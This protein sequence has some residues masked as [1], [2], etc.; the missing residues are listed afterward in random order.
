MQNKSKVSKVIIMFLLISIVVFCMVG[1][2]E[3]QKDDLKSFSLESQEDLS[4]E[5]SIENAEVDE[6]ITIS[7]TIYVYVCGAVETPGVYELKADARVY[8]AIACAGGLKEDADPD[9]INQA[10]LLSDGEQIYIPTQEEVAQG[11]ISEQI[12]KSSGDTEGKIDIN[13]ATKEE[14]MTLNGIGESR[15]ENIL[16]YR[17]E[18]GGF[19][20][21]EDLMN[22][23][24]IKEGIF[25]KIK[26]SITV[27]TGS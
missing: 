4:A 17:Q 25:Q 27:N 11:G 20:C 2:A 16:R 14:L 23:E 15:A 21:I 3:E 1:C 22:V 5:E 13:I 26:D 19:Q 9:Y 7:E 8:N 6:E 12:A 10:K 24:G 18:Q